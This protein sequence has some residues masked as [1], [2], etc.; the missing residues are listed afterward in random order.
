MGSFRRSINV[1]SESDPFEVNAQSPRGADDITSPEVGTTEYD[2]STTTTAAGAAVAKKKKKVRRVKKKKSVVNESEGS[3][4]DSMK[5]GN[6]FDAGTTNQ[7][8]ANDVPA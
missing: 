6:Q 3:E 4:V 7:Q 8:L 5:M 2:T 1:E